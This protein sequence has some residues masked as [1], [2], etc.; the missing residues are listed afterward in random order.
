MKLAGSAASGF[1]R[2]PDPGV[3]GALLH[4]PDGGLV[5]LRRQ[6]L[7]AALTE[8]DDLRLARIGAAEARKDPAAV[9]D[10]LRA[11]GFFPGRRVVLVEDAKDGLAKTLDAVL[12]GATEED[13]FLVVTATGLAAR[14]ALRK[15]FEGGRSLISMAFY[16]DAPDGPAVERAFAA[17][18]GRAGLTP[19][20]ARALADLG[21]GMDPGSFHQLIEKISVFSLDQVEPLDEAAVLGQGPASVETELDRL[22]DAAAEGQAGQVG[23]LLRRL[24]TAGVTPVSVIIAA[25][26]QF[27]QLMGVAHAP[28]GVEAGLGRLRPPAF[29]PRRRALGRQASLW[30]PR[31]DGA[32][33]L[34]YEADRRLRTPGA[35]PEMAVVERC[36][37]RL[38][39]MAAARR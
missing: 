19:D 16:P 36:L 21:A 30:G 17:A 23:V 28:D 18:G 29:G 11:R 33:G 22:I 15:L 3:A 24:G 37:L 35:L 1:C 2:A 4:G 25:G 38:A 7:V 31:I 14:S 26:R 10:A 27:R 13:A 6:E 34:I 20:A 5:A 9:G 32:L 8:G 39:M 12:E